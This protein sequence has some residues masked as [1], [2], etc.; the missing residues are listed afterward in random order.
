MWYQSVSRS[1]LCLVLASALVLA[2]GGTPLRA[3]PAKS[4]AKINVKATAAK[5]DAE[6]KRL[7]SVTLT[8][9]PGWHCYANPVGNN[10]LTD[11]QTTVRVTR[12]RTPVAAQVTYPAGKLIRDKLV[13][14]Y[15]VYEGTVT[16]EAKVPQGKDETGAL[17]VE[18]RF[19]ACSEKTC[20]PPT[21]VTVPLQ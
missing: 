12:G 13:G 10:D 3:A 5:L 18:V 16:I 14:D 6:G 17:Q 2:L 1:K 4:D 9:D 21:T 15:Q 11:S 19:Q 7:V 20:L 8:I